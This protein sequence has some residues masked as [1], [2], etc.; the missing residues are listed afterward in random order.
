MRSGDWE[1][2]LKKRGEVRWRKVD[3]I[4]NPKTLFFPVSSC[5]SSKK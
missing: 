5:C 3:E 4:Y 2:G 1:K